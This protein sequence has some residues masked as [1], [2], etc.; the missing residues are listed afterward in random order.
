[1]SLLAETLI[2]L[3]AAIIAVSISRRLGLGSVLGYLAAGI[4][5]GPFGLGLVKD[6][7]HILHFAELGVVLLLFVVGLEL[8]PARLWVMR[9]MVFGL[10]SLQIVCSAAA[11]ALIVWLLDFSTT[12]A[13][14]IGLTLALSSTAFV[15]QLLAEKKQLNSAH[16][17]AAFSILL[18][19]DLAAI[20][21]IAL[22]PLLGAAATADSGFNV[23]KALLMVGTIVALVVGGRLLLRP[24]LRIVA[25]SG[26][27][28]IFTAT[29]LLVVIGSALLMQV[30]GT[31]M[32]LGAFLAGML[33]ADSEY[34]HQLEADIAP[35]KGL[36]LGLFFIAVGMTVNLGLLLSTPVVI[37]AIAAGLM[38]TKIVVLAPL[39]RAFGSCNWGSAFKTA[40]LMSQ[41]GEFGFVLFAIA[42]RGNI[43]EASIIDP[44]ILAISV[45]MML[46][47]L[48]YFL[49]ERLAASGD[50]K[51][52]GEYDTPE[53][54][55]DGI[56][57]AGFGRVGQIIG[58]VLQISDIAFTAIDIDSSQVEVVRRY[59]N[60][61]HFGDVGRADLLRAAGA[62]RAKVY[63]IAI[64]DIE[65]S[66]RAAEVALKNFPHMTIIARARNRLH[67]HKLMDVGVTHIFRET[68]LSSLAMTEDTLTSVGMSKEAAERV[69]T[70]FKDR[71]ERLL[72][73]QHSMY[74]SEEKLIQSV[75]DTARELS[76][77]MKDDMKR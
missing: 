25:A 31:S 49:I 28:E 65:T 6:P 46:T 32:V 56:I 2:Y 36:L 50:N 34:R 61:V 69:V 66:L 59:G 16:G 29:A 17:R 76:Q 22:F 52:D 71:D 51:V 23:G 45:S 9:R 41:G 58:R 19:Q 13:V 47:P 35:F 1:M 8:K 30:S 15:L 62:E 60:L 68:L 77:V 27:P 7:E 20:P 37:L 3:V 40:A 73:E 70:A 67:A 5:I 24:V 39:A 12:S 63:V 55:H 75:K 33:L 44:L 21:M 42:A 4:A 53:D 14:V 74:E 43:L 10:G 48:V 26:L 38:L 57:I 54:H 64:G 18:Q 72:R 11:I